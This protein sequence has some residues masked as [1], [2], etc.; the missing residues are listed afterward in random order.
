MNLSD[1][2]NFN[3]PD[4]TDWFNE[5]WDTK[6]EKSDT[7]KGKIKNLIVLAYMPLTKQIAHSLARRTNDPVEDI[8]QVGLIGLI[9]AINNYKPEFGASFKTYATY[10]IVGEIRHYLRDKAKLIKVPREI[11]ELSYRINHFIQELTEKLGNPPTEEEIALE[12]NITTRQVQEAQTVERRTTAIST[13][14]INYND[15]DLPFSIEEKIPTED[16]EQAFDDFANK[17]VLKDALKILTDKEREIIE[18]NFFEGLSQAEIARELDMSKMQVS[19]AIKKA[20]KKM[21]D[22]IVK[23]GIESV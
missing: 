14:D 21:F 8:T 22:Y 10:F 20:L 15:D 18:F 7:M 1:I 12:M 5:L 16:Y 19:R 9:K 17:M 3:I 23:K 2:V 11:Y 4:T 13:S 6:S